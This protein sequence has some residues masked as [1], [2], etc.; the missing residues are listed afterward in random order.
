MTAGCDQHGL[1]T[2]RTLTLSPT[3]GGLSGVDALTA[4]TPKRPKNAGSRT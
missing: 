4:M 2:S 1:T 3:G